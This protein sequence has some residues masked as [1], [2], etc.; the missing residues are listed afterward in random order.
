M[1]TVGFGDIVPSTQT[2]ALIIIFIEMVSCI[3][4]AYNINIIGSILSDIK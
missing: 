1:F 4:L 3:I 2:E